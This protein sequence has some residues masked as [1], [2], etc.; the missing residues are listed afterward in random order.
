MAYEIEST[1]TSE[2]LYSNFAGNHENGPKYR[3]IN[4]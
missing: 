2:N 3:K 1:Q 4:H